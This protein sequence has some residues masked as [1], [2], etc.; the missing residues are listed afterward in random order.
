MRSDFL[1]YISELSINRYYCEC[2][3]GLHA[4]P[5]E[6]EDEFGG[7]VMKYWKRGISDAWV[8]LKGHEKSNPDS[9]SSVF[10]E[11]EH[12]IVMKNC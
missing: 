4:I 7:L 10:E 5:E 6:L 12:F 2:G 9:W 1:K 3:N 11:S 8:M